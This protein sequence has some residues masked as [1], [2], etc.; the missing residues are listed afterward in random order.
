M[1]VLTFLSDFGSDSHYMA[2]FRGAMHRYE[3]KTP[4]LEITG[5]IEPYD[6]V[7]TAYLCNMVYTDFPTGSI[8][9]LATQAVSLPS[10]RHLVAAYEGHFFIAPDNG[11]LSLVFGEEFNDYYL[12]PNEE[13]KNSIQ[14]VYLP[15]VKKMEDGLEM[16]RVATK[17]EDVLVKVG[18]NPVDDGK[19]LRGTVLFVDHLGSAYTNITKEAF[20]R[21][22]EDEKFGIQ[23]SR[24]SE[25]TRVTTDVAEVQE[26][27]PLCYFSDHGYLVVAMKRSSAERLLNLRKYKVVI[28]QK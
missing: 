9:V 12:I 27:D 20:D 11:V 3:L 10:T 23:L 6:I 26:G 24:Y 7:E 5:Q 15:F 4:F 1:S 25:I 19:V 13:N 2:S 28:I 17:T 21:F 14:S 16:N 18:I 8:H 22:T